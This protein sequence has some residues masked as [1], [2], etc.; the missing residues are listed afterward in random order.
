[1][2]R[3]DMRGPAMM[4][5]V[6]SSAAPDRAATR[7]LSGQ[8]ACPESPSVNDNDVDDEVDDEADDEQDN[9]AVIA[10]IAERN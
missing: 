2:R 7:S 10:D 9:V 6:A 3:S 8:L 5:W 4:L 1:M